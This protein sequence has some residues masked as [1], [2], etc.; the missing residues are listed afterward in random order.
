MMTGAELLQHAVK[1]GF[2]R[3]C[4]LPLEELIGQSD[5]GYSIHDFILAANIFAM[6]GVVFFLQ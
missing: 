5:I 2:Y 3:N 4:G 6:N 1:S